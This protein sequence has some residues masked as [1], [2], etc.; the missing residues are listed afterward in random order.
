M[1]LLHV[2]ALRPALHKQG[3]LDVPIFLTKYQG[4]R[5]V[6]RQKSQVAEGPK[7]ARSAKW[8]YTPGIQTDPPFSFV[9]RW[10][11][12]SAAQLTEQHLR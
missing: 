8:L 6:C 10:R 4:T 1:C 11:R 2:C 5:C 12:G 7:S 3:I 9:H